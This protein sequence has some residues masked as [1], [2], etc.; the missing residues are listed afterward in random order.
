MK[1][2]IP[3]KT[4]SKIICVVLLLLISIKFSYAQNTA[5]NG[6]IIDKTGIAIPGA[7]IKIK[8]TSRATI[9]DQNGNFSISAVPPGD[10]VLV[11]TF[12]GYLSKETIISQSQRANP[13]SITLSERANEMD[14]VLVTGV[15][16]KRKRMDASVGCH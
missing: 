3:K 15:F 5:V 6:K 4:T 9:S 11:A 13:L 8:G 14:E 12:L 7:S 1:R 2:I 10:I 16:D